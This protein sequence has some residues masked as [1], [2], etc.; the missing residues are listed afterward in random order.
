MPADQFLIDGTESVFDGEVAY[1]GGHLGKEYGLEHEV[2][3]FSGEFG[4]IATVDGVHDFVAFLEEVG[5]DGI[6]GLFAIPGATTWGTKT[7]HD[8]DKPFKLFAWGQFLIL[9]VVVV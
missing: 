4:P 1:F 6:E 5:F 3:E 8:A 7:G 9:G 2:A